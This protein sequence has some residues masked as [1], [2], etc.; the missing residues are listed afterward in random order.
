MVQYAEAVLE[1]VCRLAGHEGISFHFVEG[2][3]GARIVFSDHQ[4]GFEL[5]EIPSEW[6]DRG[7]NHGVH[8]LRQIATAKPRV[9]VVRDYNYRTPAVDL[10]AA[11][12]LEQGTRG[13]VVEY[14]AH[15]KTPDEA[16]ALAKIRA[17]EAE[18]QRLTFAG[19]STS[20]ELS[21]G[22]R[23]KLVGHPRYGE[24]ELLVTEVTHDL[25]LP[26]W[27]EA[28]GAADKRY[29]NTFRASPASATYRPPRVT[30]RPRIH[31]VVTGIVQP[32][33]G[34]TL[35]GTAIIDEQ[36]RYVVQFHFDAA[37]SDGASSRPIRMAQPFAG[38]D[39]GFH[40]PLKPGTEVLVAFVDG[41]PDRPLIV[42]ALPNVETPSPVT[43]ANRDANRIKTATGVLIEFGRGS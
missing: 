16:D 37:T 3:A 2:E 25:V 18:A 43:A 26:V 11:K 10:S 23:V 29:E 20:E 6:N 22:K 42:G 15:V 5:L 38:Y 27:D 34:G 17:Q 24:Q 7:S 9:F 39:E 14:G 21:A 33:P 1:F 35:G 36:G 8:R 40:F 32:G 13:G 12:E 31:G 30:R 19:A 41:D 28:G 4:G